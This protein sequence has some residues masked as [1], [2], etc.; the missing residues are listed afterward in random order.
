MST[1]ALRARIK[2]LSRGEIRVNDLME[3]FSEIRFKCGKQVFVRDVA[4]FMA[5][6]EG[7]NKGPVTEHIRDWALIWEYMQWASTRIGMPVDLARRPP[8]YAKVLQAALPMATDAALTFKVGITKQEAN[9]VMNG[10][11]RKYTV[12]SDG[13]LNFA[14]QPTWV[15][16]Q[17]MSELSTTM[18]VGNV[19]NEHTLFD[20]FVKV[21]T[22]LGVLEA[23]DVPGLSQAK[24][25]IALFAMSRMHNITLDIPDVSAKLVLRMRGFR[26]RWLTVDAEGILASGLFRTRIP[27]NDHCEPE[28][29]QTPLPW[30]CEI[31]LTPDLKLAKLN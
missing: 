21:I 3:I 26:D 2:R 10:I 12:N 8:N 27:T 14:F 25:A 22:R 9:K 15:E 28:L 7:R 29:L 6:K 30:D 19:C 16:Y 5:H 13:T 20:D 31:E 23:K 24:T 4:D 17:L 18:T 1:A 11:L